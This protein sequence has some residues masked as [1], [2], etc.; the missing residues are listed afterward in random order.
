MP[1]R[2]VASALG[3]GAHEPV[4]RHESNA[5][6]VDD[7]VLRVAVLEVDLASHRRD[8]N[9]VPVTAYPGNNAFEVMLGCR[10]RAESQRVEQRNRARS[11][12]DDVSD[13]ASNAGGSALVRL[14][15]GRVVM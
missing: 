8:T 15:R 13:D 1:S 12:R 11:H 10:K 14:D 9:A 3:A 7:R 2:P 6:G 4:H 5:H